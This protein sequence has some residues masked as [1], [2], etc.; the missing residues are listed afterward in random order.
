M[1][2][3]V[4]KT[5]ALTKRYHSNRAVNN[6]NIDIKQGDIYGLVGKNGAGKTT[7]LRMVTGLSLPS[8]G[9]IELFGETSAGGLN[10]ARS[11]TGSI[12]ETP[13][14]FPYLSAR[15]NL[16]YYRIQR[17]IAEKEVV[18][19]SLRLVGLQDT[20]KKKFKNFSL[21]MKQR[22]GLANAIMANPD[23]LILDEPINGLDPT[24]IVEF[25][26]IL[27]R[28]N[29]E[30]NITIVISS[31]ILSELEQLATIYGFINGGELI[32][33]VSS[34]KLNE[35]LRRSLSIKVDNVEKAA[36][37]ISLLFFGT[38][39]LL[40]GLGKNFPGEIKQDTLRILAAVPLWCGAIAVG[41][42]I[43]ISISNIYAASFVYA[44]LFSATSKIL[45][46]LAY[47]VSDKFNYI[48]HIL[49]TTQLENLG[50][51]QLTS[52]GMLKAVFVGISYTVVFTVLSMIYFKKKEIK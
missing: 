23:M 43:F 44:G 33:Q 18:E 45:Q 9:E 41:T 22:L 19:K 2:N 15:K 6:I 5:K 3:T 11:R 1:N 46:V 12:I 52:Q 51:P 49:I 38:D 32:E 16:E 48:R 50:A 26:D 13:S 36:V 17:G 37:I 35:R 7:L 14:F 27:L 10:R 40:L 34:K 29:R 28:L 30:R 42:F 47:L 24:G 25:R 21:G 4:L 20:G 8:S 39:A 31:H